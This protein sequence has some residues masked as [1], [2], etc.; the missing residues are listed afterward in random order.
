MAAMT[1]H[2][3][4]GVCAAALTRLTVNGE[5]DGP[6][7][8][9][10]CRRLLDGGCDAINLLGTTGEAMSLSVPQRST[11]MRAVASSGIPL[12]ACLVGT[13]ASALADAVVLTRHAR[14]LGFAGAL[15]VPPFYFK[16]NSEDGIVDYFDELLER[17]GRPHPPVYLYHFPQLSGVWFS[18]RLVARLYARYPETII[19]L[20]DSSGEPGYAESIVAAA[21]VAVYPSSE[22]SLSVARERGFA[23][24]ISAT[25]NVTAPL[26]AAVWRSRA[27]ASA[28]ASGAD[29]RVSAVR[30]AVAEYPLVPALRAL[31]ARFTGDEA[32]RR[33]LPPL[34]AL[35]PTAEATLVERL[36][37]LDVT[38]MLSEIF[39][40][41]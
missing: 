39:A 38:K 8:A 26:A 3:I 5:P 10:H 30:E 40:C 35:S 29:K 21:P 22:A 41:A 4:G 32:W 34:R 19:G 9:E 24:C 1:K 28:A 16:K 18:P 23:G 12:E 31:V 20:K 14:D 33:M 36:D 7:T 6:A 11:V 15:V 37:E 2:T 13:G 27:S 25:L 17:V